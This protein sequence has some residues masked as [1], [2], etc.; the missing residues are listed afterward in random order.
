MHAIEAKYHKKC[1]TGLYNKFK[2]K[3]KCEKGET[4]LL[5]EIEGK[6]LKDVVDYVMETITACH[7]GNETPVFTQ[8]TLTD[9]YKERII[10][11]GMSVESVDAEAF[12]KVAHCTSTQCNNG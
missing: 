3:K 10:Y 12:S 7:E 11:H 8:K 2:S 1:L 5:I 9:L 6:A 4:E